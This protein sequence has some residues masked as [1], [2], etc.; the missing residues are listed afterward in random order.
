MFNWSEVHFFGSTSYKIH[1][2]ADG[3]GRGV[4]YDD[5]TQILHAFWGVFQP[6]AVR[7]HYTGFFA[8]TKN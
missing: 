2:L 1:T 3:T 8:G 4:L 5:F 6:H 7:F